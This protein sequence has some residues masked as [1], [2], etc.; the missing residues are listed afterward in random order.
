M[1][2]RSTA[3][4]CGAIS[5]DAY[6]EL[7]AFYADVAAAYRAELAGLADAGCRYVQLDDTNLAYLCDDKMREGARKRGDDPY[8]PVPLLDPFAQPTPGSPARG[9]LGPV[10]RH[11]GPEGSWHDSGFV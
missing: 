9:L 4:R 11:E 6:P 3:R 1:W 2:S 8:G 10:A 5:K 7:E